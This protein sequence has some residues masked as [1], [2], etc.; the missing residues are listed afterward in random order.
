VSIVNK[1]VKKII[2]E[3]VK[4]VITGAIYYAIYVV[5]LPFLF[6]HFLNMPVNTEGIIYY[7]WFFISLGVAEA[8]L[9]E[10]II[11]IPVSMISVLLRALILY[12]VL[13]GGHI[14]TGFS[15]AGTRITAELD[16]SLLLYTIIAFSLILGTLDAISY[17]RRTSYHFK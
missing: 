14:S 5:A 9:E 2:M 10:H 1:A 12:E 13:N 11:Y 6:S 4:G 8:V 3:S 15:Y 17:F 16:I 7:I